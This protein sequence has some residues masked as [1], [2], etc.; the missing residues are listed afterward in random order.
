MNFGLFEDTAYPK[1]NTSWDIDFPDPLPNENIAAEWHREGFEDPVTAEYINEVLRR[2]P[3]VGEVY[4]GIVED[5]AAVGDPTHV[6]DEAAVRNLIEHSLLITGWRIKN[7][8]EYF[9]IKNHW[10]DGWVD[11]GYAK[12]KRDLVYRLAYPQGIVQLGDVAKRK[13]GKYAPR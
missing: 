1:R 2:Q 6:E 7:G 11:Q 4:M 10:G 9:E 3:M 5:E 12:V 8:V 13:K